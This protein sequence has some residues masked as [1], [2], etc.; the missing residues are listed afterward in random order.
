MTS[1]NPIKFVVYLLSTFNLYILRYL[2]ITISFLSVG[3]P[4]SE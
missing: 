1:F 4:F 2:D 3:F